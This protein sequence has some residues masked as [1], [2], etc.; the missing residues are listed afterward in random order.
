MKSQH[1]AD[2]LYVAKGTAV[3]LGL[4]TGPAMVNVPDVVGS[5]EAEAEGV[6]TAAGL[7]FGAISQQNSDAVSL[8]NVISQSLP[9]GHVGR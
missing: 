7:L 1:P 9:A 4:F 2:R 6:L 3:D 5:T 8:G